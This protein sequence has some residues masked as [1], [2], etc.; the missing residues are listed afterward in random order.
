MLSAALAPLKKKNGQRVRAREIERAGTQVEQTHYASKLK[1]FCFAAVTISIAI[2]TFLAY[3]LWLVACISQL[4]F[5][6][7]YL[8]ALAH[9]LIRVGGLP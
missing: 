5:C 1:C 4:I 6:I 7:L 3:P 8:L 2:C 9:F